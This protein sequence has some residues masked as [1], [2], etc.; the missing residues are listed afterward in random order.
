MMIKK[1]CTVTLYLFLYL[2][3]ALLTNNS[4]ASDT[5]TST[6][7]QYYAP[8][9][10]VSLGAA[11]RWGDSPYKD[12]ATI[13]SVFNDNSF[14]LLP[15]YLYEGKRFFTRGSSAGVH[16]YKNDTLVIDAI[17]NYRFLRLEAESQSYF[18]GLQDRRQ[19]IDGGVAIT[20]A[21]DYGALSISLV[22]DLLNRHQGYEWAFSYRYRWEIANFEISPYA[23]YIYQSNDLVDYYFGVNASEALPDRPL[24]QASSANFWRLGVGISYKVSERLMAFTNIAFEQLDASV[25][26]SPLVDDKHLTTAALGFAYHFGSTFKD[27]SHGLYAGSSNAD[28]AVSSG[29]W[30]LRVN[31]GYQAEGPFHRTHR[32]YL[33]RSEDV[34]TYMAGITLGNR[35]S[36]GKY[37]DYWGRL[38][39]NR[40]FEQGYQSDFWEY[41]AYVM[42][43][44]SLHSAK[45]DN[46][47]FRYGLGFGFSYA[48]QIPTV[49]KLKQARR[50]ENTARFLNYLEAQFD[51]PLNIIFGQAAS[52]DCYTGITLIHRSGIFATSDILGNVSGGSDMVTWHLECKL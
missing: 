16:F 7:N 4:V 35:L 28:E 5:A 2:F 1:H 41:N 19:T 47:L 27:T 10:S 31:T 14:D 8:T 11:L 34:N 52:K 36:R 6:I 3:S 30:S 50:G 9:G 38:T 32:G 23:S 45:T 46:E 44:T 39:L 25:T 49:E 17:I 12:V 22:N 21:T 37:F 24:Y 33:K 18:A 15:L 42:A 51:V 48:A 29:D 20:T 43:M 13:A 26:Q 40:R